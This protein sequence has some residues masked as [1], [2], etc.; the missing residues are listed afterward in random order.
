MPGLAFSGHCRCHSTMATSSRASAPCC[1]NGHM[2]QSLQHRFQLFT[3]VSIWF[4]WITH[5]NL[6]VSNVASV[7]VGC[8]RQTSKLAFDPFKQYRLCDNLAR[9]GVETRFATA[10]A[11]FL[12]GGCFAWRRHVAVRGWCL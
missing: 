10:G 2:R 9:M 8:N 1:D 3:S 4:D 11:R 7:V 12:H 6:V 5:C